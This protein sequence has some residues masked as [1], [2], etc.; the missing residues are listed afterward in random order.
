MSDVENIAL[1]KPDGI[2]IAKRN[3]LFRRTQPFMLTKGVLELGRLDEI[4]RLL[5][6]YDDFSEDNDPYGEH[7]FGSFDFGGKKLFWK[8]DYYDQQLS[9]WCDPLSPDCRRVLTVMLAEEY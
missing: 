7:D 8:F 6:D 2:E 9:G 1:G 4:T 3:D 5:R